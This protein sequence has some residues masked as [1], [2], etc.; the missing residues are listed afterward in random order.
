MTTAMARH[1]GATPAHVVAQRNGPSNETRPPFTCA[2]STG[3]TE[4][5]PAGSGAPVAIVIA[6][7]GSSRTG[8]SPA[9]D[10]PVIGSSS[11]ASAARTA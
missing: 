7:C 4:S 3:T 2:R 11:P 8:S 9:N 5:A 6:V 1:V 10:C